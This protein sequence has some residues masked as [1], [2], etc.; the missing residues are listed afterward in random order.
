MTLRRPR[1]SA[2]E[3]AR[4]GTETYERLVRPQVETGNLGRIV[5]IDVDTGG[6]NSRRI[7]SRPVSGC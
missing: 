2:E 3:H 6:F 4:L 5:A 1:Y 7:P